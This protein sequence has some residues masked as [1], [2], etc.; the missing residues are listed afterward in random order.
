MRGLGANK[1]LV[2]QNS[3]KEIIGNGDVNANAADRYSNAILQKQREMASILDNGQTVRTCVSAAEVT[4]KPTN[5]SERKTLADEDFPRLCVDSAGDNDV[6]YS[7][8]LPS[9]NH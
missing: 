2:M 7:S 6:G 8:N 3:F 4:T 1:P 9:R 5:A